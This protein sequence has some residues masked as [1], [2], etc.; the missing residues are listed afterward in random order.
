MSEKISTPPPRIQGT[1]LYCGAPTKRR[2]CCDRHRSAHH[3]EREPLGTIG[4][5]RQLKDRVRVIVYFDR[6]ELTHLLKPEF[7]TG[8]R[9]ALLP[10]EGK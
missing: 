2:F 1:C 3:R 5:V 9:I 6:A 10:E 4:G 8:N 7:L